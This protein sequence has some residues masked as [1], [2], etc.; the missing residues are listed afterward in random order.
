MR[1]ITVQ[2][3]AGGEFFNHETGK[4]V[5]DKGIYIRTIRIC[6]IETTLPYRDLRCRGII[7]VH[8]SH[9]YYHM[10]AWGRDLVEWMQNR[11]AELAQEKGL[12]LIEN[13]N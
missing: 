6:E 4:T 5:G 12:P 2:D 10:S 8:E 13:E 11:A 7:E 1:A 9:S 3:V